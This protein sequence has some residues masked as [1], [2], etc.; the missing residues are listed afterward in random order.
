MGN[1]GWICPVCKRGKA[2][3]VET[4][5]CVEAQQTVTFIPVFPQPYTITVPPTPPD[6]TWRI[7]PPVMTDNSGWNPHVRYYYGGRIIQ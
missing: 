4:C 5:D 7:L 3:H 2:P 1:E 6:N